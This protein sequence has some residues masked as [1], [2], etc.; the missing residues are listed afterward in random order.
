MALLPSKLSNW[1]IDSVV[2]QRNI[3][4]FNIIKVSCSTKCLNRMV[5]SVIWKAVFL[6]ALRLSESSVVHS[7]S[8]RSIFE[9]RSSFPPDI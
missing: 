1:M 6:P 2:N 9:S 7:S 3:E 4:Q 8:D 5:E